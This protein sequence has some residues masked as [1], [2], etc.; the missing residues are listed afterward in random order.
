MTDPWTAHERRLLT[1]LEQAVSGTLERGRWASY[2]RERRWFNFWT[3]ELTTRGERALVDL[4][5]RFAGLA[6]GG[7]LK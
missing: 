6:A 7:S 4:R 3:R 2:L 5:A 1:A